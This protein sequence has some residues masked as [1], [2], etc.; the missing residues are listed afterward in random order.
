VPVLAGLAPGVLASP[1]ADSMEVTRYL[2][3]R[4][5]QLLPDSH[6]DQ[7]LE[8]LNKLHE[9]NYFSLAFSDKPFGR[10]NDLLLATESGL[11]VAEIIL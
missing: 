11:V 10:L 6:K 4:H 7:I 5:P 2:W 8:K 1:I 9:I 3:E